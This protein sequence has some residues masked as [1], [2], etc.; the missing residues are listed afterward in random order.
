MA[1]KIPN[2]FK[3]MLKNVKI[4]LGILNRSIMPLV[5]KTIDFAATA[6]SGVGTYQGVIHDNFERI[7]KSKDWIVD[8]NI[9][10]QKR[11][12]NNNQRITDI[13]YDRSEAN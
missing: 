7:S 8:K 5:P 12:I 1:G 9:C 13:Q 3:N 6:Q 2:Y 10:V 4:C 11:V